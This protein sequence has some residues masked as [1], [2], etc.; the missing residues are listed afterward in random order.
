M[1]IHG[2]WSPITQQVKLVFAEDKAFLGFGLREG[3]EL[4]ASS[5][6]SLPSARGTLDLV[7]CSVQKCVYFN[8]T[9]DVDCAQVPPWKLFLRISLW[10]NCIVPLIQVNRYRTQ[11]AET[12]VTHNADGVTFF[13]WSKEWFILTCSQHDSTWCDLIA[14]YCLIQVQSIQNL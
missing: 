14:F 13:S 3:Y 10:S 12:P 6:S 5:V 2:Y 9:P 1:G 8:K 11:H 7:F 4:P